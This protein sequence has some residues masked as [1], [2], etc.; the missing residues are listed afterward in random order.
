MKKLL[1]SALSLS[2]LLAGCG[3]VKKDESK[4]VEEK[5]VKKENVDAKKEVKKDELVLSKENFYNESIKLIKQSDDYWDD[6]WFKNFN[7]I[8]KGDSDGKSELKNITAI[9]EQMSD[10]KD[11]TYSMKAPKEFTDEQKSLFESFKK[12]LQFS[13]DKKMIGAGM[14]ERNIKDGDVNEDTNL[15][16]TEKVAEANK[17]YSNALNSLLKIKEFEKSNKKTSNNNSSIESNSNSK[18]I[19][20]KQNKLLDIKNITNRNDLESIIYG[21]NYSE[22][23]KIT[24]YNSAVANG[25]IPQGNVMEGPASAAY[26]SSLRVES[27]QEKS[28]Y[29]SNPDPNNPATAKYD[30]LYNSSNATDDIDPNWSPEQN[31]QKQANKS[32]ASYDPNNPYMNLPN[33]EWRKNAGGLSSGEMQTRNAILNG[34]YQGEDADQILEAINYYEQKYAK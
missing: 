22:V 16:V 30:Y 33:Q 14:L 10:Y 8:R 18:V 9:K 28:A 2:V 25:I 4:K 20:T 26:E 24:A 11:E 31:N 15:T 32:N 17:Y 3:E 27:G 12:D 1:I 6:N 13:M 5:I 29:T 19:A 21:G 34:T 7:P 23:E